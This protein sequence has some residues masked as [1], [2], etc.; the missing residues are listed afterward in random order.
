MQITKDDLVN[1]S[2]LSRIII[3]PG[4]EDKMLT[5]MQAILG[6]VSEINDVKGHIKEREVTAKESKHYNIT[7][8]DVITHSP[9]SNTVAILN[10][11]PETEDGYVKVAQVLK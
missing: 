5:D 1:L 9:G 10:E 3:A 6:Y 4:T 8:E 2:N 11:A 7:R